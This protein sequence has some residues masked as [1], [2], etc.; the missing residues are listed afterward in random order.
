MQEEIQKGEGGVNRDKTR[1]KEKK[2]ERPNCRVEYK[3]LYCAELLYRYFSKPAHL[4]P[5]SRG[6]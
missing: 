3:Y 5:L 1:D 2:N 6:E 4:G